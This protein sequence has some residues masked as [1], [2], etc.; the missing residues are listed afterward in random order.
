MSAITERE[1][2]A[3]RYTRP[4]VEK[5]YANQTLAVDLSTMSIAI[6]PVDAQAKWVFSGGRGFD[7]STLNFQYG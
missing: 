3:M 7:L 6:K 1:K 2:A 4:S 5:G